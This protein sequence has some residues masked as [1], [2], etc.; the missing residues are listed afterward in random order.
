M[1]ETPKEA[2]LTE[3]FRAIQDIR[4]GLPVSPTASEAVR[5]LNTIGRIADRA[6]NQA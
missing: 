3:A 4:R 6:V 1:P 2:Q 5:A